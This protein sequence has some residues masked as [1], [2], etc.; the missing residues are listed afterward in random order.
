LQNDIK[1]NLKS[2][3][4]VCST[5]LGSEKLFTFATIKEVVSLAGIDRTKLSHMEQ[6]FSGGS[7][8]SQLMN[9]IDKLVNNLLDDEFK[10]F[11][12]ILIEEILKRD[13]KLEDKFNQYLNRLHWQ[14]YNGKLIPLEILDLT[15][16]EEL[17]SKSHEDLVKAS[18]RFKNGDLTGALASACSAID[19]VTYDIYKNYN[20]GNPDNASFQEK[21][22]R[23]IEA[24]NIMV[25]IENE[26]SGIGWI[27]ADT[28]PLNKNLE[29][30]LNQIAF[31]MQKLRSK[32]SDVHGSKIVLKPLV[33]DSIKYAEILIR[34][35]TKK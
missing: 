5:I 32:M 17:H 24:V 15:E 23:S 10:S 14:L 25:D 30:S 31:V 19:S 27:D 12:D 8:K 1:Q 4:A 34:M 33:F 29:G 26:L 2:V 28:T 3:W 11:I 16:L 20:L 6:N 18:I 21:C 22:K 7:S 35:M 13:K 9:E